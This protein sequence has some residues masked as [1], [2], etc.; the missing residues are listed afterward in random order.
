MSLSSIGSNGSAGLA[1]T[2]AGPP[3]RQ[4]GPA[5]WPVATARSLRVFA[6]RAGQ[7]MAVPLG[8]LAVAALEAPQPRPAIT[9]SRST[10]IW[11]DLGPRPADRA[12][13]VSR[14]YPVSNGVMGLR[15]AG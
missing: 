7:L 13:P 9:Q 11:A 14:P 4:A 1:R 12:K 15:K 5:P 10:G 2:G 3:H 6:S 8:G